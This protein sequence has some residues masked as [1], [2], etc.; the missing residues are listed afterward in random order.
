MPSAYAAIAFSAI[1][2][3]ILSLLHFLK[4]ELDP[5][6]RMISEYEIGRLGWMMRL[7]F[8][9]WGASVLAIV[10]ATRPF[11]QTTSRLWFVLIATA[12]VGAGIF[13]TN[14]ITDTTPDWVNTI[15]TFCGAIVILSF[16]VVATLAIRRLL[17]HQPWSVRGRTLIVGTVL[18]WIGV[19]ALIS[20]LITYRVLEPSADGFGLRVYIGWPNR[21]MVVAYIA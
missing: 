1:F 15:H 13:R 2:V 3:I 7:A 14:P 8:F 9:S 17:H 5:A 12:L 4:P 18:T 6:W 21:F 20:S 16:P 10:V 11:L 19:A